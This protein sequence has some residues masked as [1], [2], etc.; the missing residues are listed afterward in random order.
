MHS[1]RLLF[2]IFSARRS[3]FDPIPFHVAFLMDKVALGLRFRITFLFFFLSVSV[4]QCSLLVHP[5]TE[6]ILTWQL[7]VL[8]NNDIQRRLKQH[9]FIRHL[10]YSVRYSVVPIISSLL[11]IWLH[12]FLITTLVYSDTKY[13]APFMTL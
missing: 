12:Y 8:L 11:T 6:A 10:A 7:T 1:L 13:S 5:T 9:R 4:H 3:G 2:A